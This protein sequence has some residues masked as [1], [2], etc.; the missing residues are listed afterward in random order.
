M[1]KETILEEI[2]ED[3]DIFRDSFWRKKTISEVIFEEIK[4]FEVILEDFFFFTYTCNKEAILSCKN[5]T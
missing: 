3:E 4:P 2:F 1:I 5:I